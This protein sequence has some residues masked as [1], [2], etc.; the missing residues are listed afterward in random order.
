VIYNRILSLSLIALLAAGCSTNARIART[1]TIGYRITDSS[2]VD[3]SLYNQI[4]PYQARLFREMNAVV[5]YS[6]QLLERG[7]PEGLLGDFVAD[8]CMSSLSLT[9]RGEQAVDFLFL[10]NGG[11]RNPLP[12]GELTKGNIFELMPFENE[13][14][15]LTIEDSL[16]KKIFN[17]IASKGG[18]PVAGV[19]FNIKNKE[20]LNITI[21]NKP[22][23]PGKPYRVA[24]SDYLAGGGDHFS[25]LPGV[26]KKES[27]NLKVRDAIFQYLELLSKSNQHLTV[28]LDHRISD[29]E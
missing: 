28:N 5:A 19:R 3:S 17:F 13:L 8:A 7:I 10:N 20:A 26:T 18:A 21:N 25:F 22:L 27:S 29:A 12:K 15:I 6:D 23:Q 4:V 11:L 2:A 16:V 9:F 24:T 1:E 14:V